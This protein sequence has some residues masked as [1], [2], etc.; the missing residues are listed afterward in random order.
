MDPEPLVWRHAA[1]RREECWHGRTGPGAQ[2]NAEAV[3]YRFGAQFDTPLSSPLWVGRLVRERYT[4][5]SQSG[6]KKSEP[7]PVDGTKGDNFARNVNANDAA[8]PRRFLTG[9]RRHDRGKIHSVRSIRP[10]LAA[11]DKDD[12]MGLYS[13]AVTNGGTPD[14]G[15]SFSSTVSTAPEALGIDPAA[16]PAQCQSQLGTN[17]ATLCTERI[18]RWEV[19]E[20]DAGLPTRDFSGCKAIDPISGQQMGCELGSVFHSTPVVVGPPNEFLRDESYDQFAVAQAGRPTVLYVSTT[21]GQLHAFKVAANNPA[22]SLKVDSLQNN[23]L[24]SFI[25]PSVLPRLLT[26]YNQQSILLDGQVVVQDVVLEKSA[27]QAVAG[28]GA[29]G[30]TWRTILVT[31]GGGGGGYYFA[32]DVTDPTNP[33]FLWQISQDFEGAE[34][35]GPQVPTPAIATI[36]M[37]ESSG[38]TKDV[39]VAILRGRSGPAPRRELPSCGRAAIPTDHARQP[40]ARPRAAGP[41]VRAARSR[42]CASTRARCIRTFVSPNAALT[43]NLDTN[44]KTSAPFDSPL[45]GV[46]VPYPAKAGQIANCIYIGDADGT[47]WRVNLSKPDPD[48]WT[49]DMMWDGYDGEGAEDG[50][51]IQTPPIVSVDNLGQPGDPLLDRRSGAHHIGDAEDAPLVAHRDRHEHVVQREGELPHRHG[52]RRAR[53]RTDLA[54]LRA[55]LTSRRSPPSRSRVG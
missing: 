4:C 41:R 23:E 47:L 53:D 26:T 11:H 34:L 2:G 6:V 3:G 40:P 27:A 50:Q 15:G 46:P 43:P 33:E 25:P 1:P 42:S 9:H 14:I 48:D 38:V 8:N 35:F 21:D 24:W 30:P 51:P 45:T 52:E 18:V 16:P 28:S 13:G 22:D 19:G 55:P 44:R 29:G 12:G 54:L 37:K 49:V 32:L 7:Q 5:V 36:T 20:V 17:V 10:K 39:A 31:G